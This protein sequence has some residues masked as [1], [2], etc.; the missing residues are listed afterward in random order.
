MNIKTFEAALIAVPVPLGGW[1]HDHSPTEGMAFAEVAGGAADMEN[2]QSILPENC[3]V[4]ATFRND[5]TI[6]YL[7]ICSCDQGCAFYGFL[8]NVPG[9]LEVIVWVEDDSIRFSV[10]W[11][12]DRAVFQEV[13]Y[14][15][16]MFAGTWLNELQEAA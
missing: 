5:L 1:R 10:C 6:R 3:D 8:F 2:G 9:R 12:G 14:Q 13:A 15:L 4:A 16:R 7:G 11:R